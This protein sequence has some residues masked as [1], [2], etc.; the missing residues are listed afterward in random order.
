MSIKYSFLLVVPAL[1]VFSG[2]FRIIVGYH[3]PRVL[4]EKQWQ[5]Y[6][7]KLHITHTPFHTQ[8]YFEYFKTQNTEIKK[9]MYQPCQVII[10]KKERLKKWVVNCDVGGFPKLRW[11][12]PALLKNDTL[13]VFNDSLSYIYTS[14][15]KIPFSEQ[16]TTIIVLWSR[17]LNKTSK[18]LIREVQKCTQNSSAK[19]YYSNIDSFF[20][21]LD[22]QSS[23]R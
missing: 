16:D 13:G 7:K 21:V 18:Q 6:E 23:R 14:T 22:K 1:V 20:V 17:V 8:K 4:S 15:V 19:V 9:R 10:F 12:I 3:K 5:R 11:N 2:C